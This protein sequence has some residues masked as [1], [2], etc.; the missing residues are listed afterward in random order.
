MNCDCDVSAHPKSQ[1]TLLRIIFAG[2]IQ[3]HKLRIRRIGYTI[4]YFD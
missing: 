4:I 3:P 2:A 1:H